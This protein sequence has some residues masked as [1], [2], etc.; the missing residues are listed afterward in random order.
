MKLYSKNLS[1]FMIVNISII[2]LL[3]CLTFIKYSFVANNYLTCYKS[4]WQCTICIKY[5]ISISNKS[6]YL[7]GATCKMNRCKCCFITL[8][9]QF[10]F[11]LNFYFWRGEEG[12]GVCLWNKKKTSLKL[13]VES[14]SSLECWEGEI[15]TNRKLPGG[16]LTVLVV[17]SLS[18]AAFT[19]ESPWVLV[20]LALR[21]RL[22][23]V[24]GTG[25]KVKLLIVVYLTSFS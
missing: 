23:Q 25:Q 16:Q 6:F 13:N 1:H 21:W 17:M 20:G 7:P 9:F 14:E 24:L 12:R 19:P 18:R 8:F 15:G 5:Y 4:Y 3:K 11:L 2:N 22:T 10:D